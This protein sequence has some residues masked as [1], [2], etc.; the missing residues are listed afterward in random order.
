MDDDHGGYLADIVRTGGHFPSDGDLEPLL[1]DASWQLDDHLLSG[2]ANGADFGDPFAVDL[3]DPLAN[4]FSHFGGADRDGEDG[5]PQLLPPPLLKAAEQDLVKAST[6]TGTSSILPKVHQIS[7]LL[8]GPAPAAAE[9]MMM[10]KAISAG[11]PMAGGAGDHYGR[12][13][14]S[15]HMA[16]PGIKRRYTLRIQQIIPAL[17]HGNI[18]AIYIFRKSQARKVVCIPA[19]AAASNRPSGEVVPSDRWAWRKYGQKPI[20]GS[21]YPRQLIYQLQLI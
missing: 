15:P 9:K 10:M 11:C 4:P 16:T 18:I 19:P 6:A 5:T 13:Q 12:V 21:P 8:I 3:Q 14:I 17:V 7:P 20:K 1:D 2:S